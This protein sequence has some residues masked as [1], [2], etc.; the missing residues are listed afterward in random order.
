MI[1]EVL[2]LKAAACTLRLRILHLLVIHSEGLFVCALTSILQ[3][4]QYNVSKHLAILKEAH[5]VIDHRRGKSVLYT[6]NPA[7]TFIIPLV[8][9]MDIAKYEL[10]QRDEKRLHGITVS[11]SIKR[12]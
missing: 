1:D 2:K 3:E 6:I 5:L 10:F 4:P 7:E 8:K 9:E 11:E 12:E